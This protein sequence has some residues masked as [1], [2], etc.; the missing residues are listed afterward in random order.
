MRIVIQKLDK[1]I[2]E[3]NIL[4]ELNFIYLS[5]NNTASSVHI[6]NNILENTRQKNN[7]L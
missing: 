6:M 4:E 7:K 2:V 1:I 3:Y 5:G